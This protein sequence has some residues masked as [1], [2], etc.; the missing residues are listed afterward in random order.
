MKAKAFLVVL[1]DIFLF[2]V[3]LAVFALFHHV[4]PHTYEPIRS[5]ISA[6]PTPSGATAQSEAGGSET[7]ATP[8]QDYAVGDFSAAFPDSD[9]GAGAE[10][11]YQTDELRIAVDMV[12]E[13]D[14]TYFVADIWVKSIE[15]LKTA[16]AQ[17]QFSSG[18]TATVRRMAQDNSA[19]F[20]VSG[21]FCGAHKTGTVIRNGVLYR[22]DNGDKD[23]CVLYY[24]GTMDVYAAD[25]FSIDEAIAN[26]AWQAWSFGPNLLDDGAAITE[27]HSSVAK[28]NP[29][30]AIGY[31]EPGHYCLVVV[32]GRQDGYSEGMTLAQLSWLMEALGCSEAYNLDGGAT[33]MMVYDND[34]ISSPSGGGRESSDI[35]Y[36]A[37]E[38][39]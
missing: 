29:R 12:Q 18:V 35:I 24:D 28:E 33:A 15:L 9:T 14:V 20:A 25:A 39:E 11:S 38:G 26:G 36:F 2:G 31:Y 32:D 16:F 1:R 7:E 19:I 34:I 27:F 3:L 17:G 21:D 13:N 5:I 10:Y 30:C 22:E 4:L 37:K 23:V 6:S 8:G